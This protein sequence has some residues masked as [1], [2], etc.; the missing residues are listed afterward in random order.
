M[1]KRILSKEL[2][3][4]LRDRRSITL[5]IVV[6]L[7]LMTGLT[8]FYDKL[9]AAP[10]EGN[11]EIAVNKEV[12]DSFIEQLQ[13]YFPGVTIEK[14]TDL[15]EKVKNKEVQ[16][17]IRVDKDWQEKI[18]GQT[19]VSI[20]LIYDP[21]S[22]TSS[23]VIPYI[24]AAIGQWE[25]AILKD[26][27]Q[28]ANMDPEIVD[29]FATE[30]VPLK[31]KD[32]AVAS[33]MLAIL[34][35]ILIPIAIANGAYPSA[36]ELFAGEKEKK[37]MEALLITPVKPIKILL[38]K[39]AAI[40]LIGIFTG[41]LCIAVLIIEINFTTNLKA[42]FEAVGDPIQFIAMS[43][44]LIIM[45]S[46]MISALLMILSMLANSVK[47]AGYYMGPVMGSLSI[48]VIVIFL[49]SE[50]LNTW[51]Y[52]IPVLNLFLFV[53]DTF[54]GQLTSL[55]FVIAMLSYVLVIIILFPIAKRMFENHRLMLGN[56]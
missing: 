54:S 56:S 17:G 2:R 42:G 14:Q 13:A 53:R 30:E 7:I 3:D 6:P 55:A 8:F 41:L 46:I 28:Q 32:N 43:T 31:D 37:T 27:L 29:V 52:L 44:G 19:P 22:Q 45:F 38:A 49:I 11:F 20:K 33:F 47:E 5:L 39:W 1:F 48:P 16:I 25:S 18:G 40:S 21:G 23:E 36:T 50:S 24:E 34:I 9:L 35:P 26:R 51:L 4:I 10:N 12:G 15:Q